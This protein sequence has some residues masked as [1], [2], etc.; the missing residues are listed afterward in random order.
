VSRRFIKEPLVFWITT[1]DPIQRDDVGGKKLTGN[2]YKITV[3]ESDR[4]GSAST[5]RLHGRRRDI[6]R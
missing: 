1:D 3:N 2:P 4:V 6:G 5:R